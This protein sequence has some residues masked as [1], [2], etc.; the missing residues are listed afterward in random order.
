MDSEISSTVLGHYVFADGTWSPALQQSTELFKAVVAD[1]ISSF[2]REIDAFEAAHLR[3]WSVLYWSDS[4]KEAAPRVEAKT[5]SLAMIATQ[6]GSLRVL[7]FLL[8]KGCNPTECCPGAQAGNGCYE[9][10]VGSKG[11]AWVWWKF[12]C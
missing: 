10:R 3:W 4:S 5:R 12:L 8:S 7:S 2:E 11:S 9:V 1:D 6:H